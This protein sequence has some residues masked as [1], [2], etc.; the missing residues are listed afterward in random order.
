MIKIMN[1]ILKA[2]I[3]ICTYIMHYIF[4]HV[5]N[6]VAGCSDINFTS[7]AIIIMQFIALCQV[8]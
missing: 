3:W 1:A 5:H 7:I 6:Y 8:C 2:Q 4:L